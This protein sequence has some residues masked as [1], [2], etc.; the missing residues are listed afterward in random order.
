VW[1][2]CS[3]SRT[4][5][6]R[7]SRIARRVQVV[8]HQL[9]QQF[10]PVALQARLQLAVLEPTGGLILQHGGQGLQP[11]L[12]RGERVRVHHGLGV[13]RRARSR[14]AANAASPSR[15]A[16]SSSPLARE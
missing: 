5:A 3:A 11:L 8:L 4:T 13:H 10:A 12:G 7:C 15:A 9:T 14:R 16:A 2:T 6:T 1:A